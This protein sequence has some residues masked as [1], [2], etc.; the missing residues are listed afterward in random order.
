VQ[1]AA[2]RRFASLCVADQRTAIRCY[3]PLAYPVRGN[4]VRTLALHSIG[5]TIGKM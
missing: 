1:P 4:A 5:S 2:L 3:A